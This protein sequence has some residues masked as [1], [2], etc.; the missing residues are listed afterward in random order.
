MINEIRNKGMIRQKTRASTRCLAKR[1]DDAK[2]AMPIAAPK[3][4]CG[5]VSADFVIL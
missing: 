3:M 4:F 1:Y 5:T 2:I